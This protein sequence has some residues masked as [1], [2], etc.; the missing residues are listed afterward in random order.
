MVYYLSLFNHEC[1][2]SKK[3]L[4][5]NLS[6]LLFRSPQLLAPPASTSTIDLSSM[7]DCDEKILFNRP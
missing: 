2:A 1:N 5:Q 6:S 3:R 7:T 4:H